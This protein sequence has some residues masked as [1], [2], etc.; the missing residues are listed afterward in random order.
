[1]NAAETI[2]S[3]ITEFCPQHRSRPVLNGL[4]HAYERAA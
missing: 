2:A 3:V 1:M 4:H